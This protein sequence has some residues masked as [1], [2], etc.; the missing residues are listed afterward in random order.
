MAITS[1]SG[2][3]DREHIIA[4]HI[5]PIGGMGAA[6]ITTSGSSLATGAITATKADII[7]DGGSRTSTPP[8]PRCCLP[9]RW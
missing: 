3:R 5:D 1:A 8:P 6:L 2:N 4:R 7:T 9:N